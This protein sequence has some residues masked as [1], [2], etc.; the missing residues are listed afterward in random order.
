MVRHPVAQQQVLTMWAS[1]PAAKKPAA[2]KTTATKKAATG[3]KK[4]VAKKT[5]GVKKAA[6]KAPVT[7]AKAP[8]AKKTTT[9]KAA[10]KPATKAAT[11]AKKVCAPACSDCAL[12][13]SGSAA[14][15]LPAAAP[16][17]C[18]H[19]TQSAYV[20][21]RCSSCIAAEGL[22]LLV[23]SEL[24]ACKVPYCLPRVAGLLLP[25]ACQD[26]CLT[27]SALPATGCCQEDNS[28]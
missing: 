15:R 20:C 24:D 25:N 16:P 10:A 8:A 1:L 3:A 9:K 17:L 12:Y 4:T 14:D 23:D 5:T 11:P 22:L 13:N 27:C 19:N 18:V 26:T 28:H 7:G 2:K 6:K 21:L